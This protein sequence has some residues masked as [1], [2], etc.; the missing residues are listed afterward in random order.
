MLK[1]T[2]VLNEM[3]RWEAGHMGRSKKSGSLLPSK[4]IGFFSAL[5]GV[6]Q[7]GIRKEIPTNQ[8]LN[9][10]DGI[11]TDFSNAQRS[12]SARILSGIRNIG[13]DKFAK[14]GGMYYTPTQPSGYKSQYNSPA[15]RAA[16]SRFAAGSIANIERAW[17][18]SRRTAGIKPP[19]VA[20][21]PPDNINT[22]PP[23]KPLNWVR[24]KRPPQTTVK[25]STNGQYVYW[26]DVDWDTSPSSTR[27]Q[28]RGTRGTLGVKPTSSGLL[29]PGGRPLLPP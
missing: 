7:K 4:P 26:R 5:K 6:I 10:G 24:R 12:R 21:T 23:P 18:I 11:V 29:P 1:G 22:Y 16:M 15:V 20:P 25:P 9:V 8:N 13:L 14:K 2:T 3:I 19:T 17:K 28:Q 27:P